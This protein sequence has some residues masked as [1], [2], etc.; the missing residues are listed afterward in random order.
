MQLPE[1]KQKPTIAV[2]APQASA[3]KLPFSDGSKPSLIETD[4]PLPV[5]Y[6]ACEYKKCYGG[7]YKVRIYFRVK[8]GEH[9]GKELE[10]WFP[11]TK[12]NKGYRAPSARSKLGAALDNSLGDW[13]SSPCGLAL[14]ADLLAETR[15]VT[16]DWENKE[17]KRR[18]MYSVVDTFWSSSLD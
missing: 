2:A 3:R 8:S 1:K 5:E 16:H 4:I 9:Q 13:K 14:V 6:I 11:V 10:C 12:R 15:V 18:Q 7:K 17:K